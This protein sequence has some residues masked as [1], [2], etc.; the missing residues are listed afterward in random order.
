MVPEFA[1]NIFGDTWTMLTIIMGLLLTIVMVIMKKVWRSEGNNFETFEVKFISIYRFFL[2]YLWYDILAQGATSIDK[3]NEVWGGGLK[4]W[5]VKKI[6][7]RSWIVR[8]FSIEVVPNGLVY[9]LGIDVKKS[10]DSTIP[11]EFVR[12]PLSI[13]KCHWHFCTS[14]A[15][16]KYGCMAWTQ[17]RWVHCTYSTYITLHYRSVQC[18]AMVSTTTSGHP[19]STQMRKSGWGC[20]P[21]QCPITTI[22]KYFPWFGPFNT[23][24]HSDFKNCYE[25]YKFFSIHLKLELRVYSRGSKLQIFLASN[26]SQFVWWEEYS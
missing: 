5:K 22:S 14:S 8:N 11:P 21:T 18:S 19:D 24:V 1:F 25:H 6:S 3:I 10:F 12:T 9:N 23:M 17:L 13:N 26:I 20:L 4:F 7:A 2:W 15:H 16:D